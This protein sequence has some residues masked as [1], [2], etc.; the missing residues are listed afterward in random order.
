MQLRGDGSRKG[1]DCRDH[2]NNGF[3]GPL[4]LPL[5]MTWSGGRSP[6]GR[7]VTSSR[8]SNLG[9][10][11]RVFLVS[12]SLLAGKKESEGAPESERQVG[13]QSADS[14]KMRS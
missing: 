6:S 3:T 9:G 8:R 12:C 4:S 7:E 13:F 1:P 5:W 10:V 2:S 11:V 14:S